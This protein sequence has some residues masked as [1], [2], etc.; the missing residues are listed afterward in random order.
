MKRKFI[1][2]NVNIKHRDWH[3]ITYQSTCLT[4]NVRQLPYQFRWFLLDTVQNKHWQH[5]DVSSALLFNRTFGSAREI[6]ILSARHKSH[7]LVS[8]LHRDAYNFILHFRWQSVPFAFN[9]Q[10]YLDSFVSLIW[11]MCL[12]ECAWLLYLDWNSPSDV[13]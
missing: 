5:Y 3:Y 7:L 4:Y 12:K 6:I 8:H 13:A 11:Y 2:L 10:K 1:Y 9:V